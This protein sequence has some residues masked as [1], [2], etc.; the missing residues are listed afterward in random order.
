MSAIDGSVRVGIGPG[1]GVG[2]ANLH[3]IGLGP[4]PGPVRGCPQMH[5]NPIFSAFFYPP[6]Q[7]NLRVTPELPKPTPPPC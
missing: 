3:L 4:G 7:R 5:R 2:S 1:P 6:P